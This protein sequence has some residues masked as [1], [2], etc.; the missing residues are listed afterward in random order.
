MEKLVLSILLV[1]LFFAGNVSADDINPDLRDY[2][3][4]LKKYDDMP[5][6]EKVTGKNKLPESAFKHPFCL[7]VALRQAQEKSEILRE[8]LKS[9]PTIQ[10]YYNEFEIIPRLPQKGSEP[11]PVMDAE[12]KVP[13]RPTFFGADT[14]IVSI[15]VNLQDGSISEGSGILK[16]VEEGDYVLSTTSM[17]IKDDPRYQKTCWARVHKVHSS[18]VKQGQRLGT[19][20][21]SGEEEGKINKVVSSLLPQLSFYVKTPGGGVERMSVQK[22][23]PAPKSTEFVSPHP[24]KEGSCWFSANDFKSLAAEPTA[25]LNLD[26]ELTGI[27]FIGEFG[28]QIP[29]HH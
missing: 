21:Y 11:T 3:D 20:F 16:D 24:D 25:L 22:L 7:A 4:I 26:V 28:S 12:G 15:K 29:V 6:S 19:L 1:T 2:A 23:R 10:T 5:Y 13:G 17:L 8:S 9:N 18:E 14:P 27:Y